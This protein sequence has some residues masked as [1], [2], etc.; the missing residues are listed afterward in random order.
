MYYIRILCT[1][2][3][4]SPPSL[5]LHLSKINDEIKVLI[6][7]KLVE[8]VQSRWLPSG[9]LRYQT[10]CNSKCVNVQLSPPSPHPFTPFPRYV[11]RSWLSLVKVVHSVKV[12]RLDQLMISW[13]ASPLHSKSLDSKSNS[14][15]HCRSIVAKFATQ[16]IGYSRNQHGSS[17][18]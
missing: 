17:L 18:C 8:T 7:F 6:W 5:S 12:A 2:S 1:R 3:F 11:V 16:D 10:V 9:P 4:S 15:V 14:T 13:K